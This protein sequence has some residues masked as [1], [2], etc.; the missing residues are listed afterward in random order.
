VLAISDDGPGFDKNELPN[1]FER[2][3]KGKKGNFGLGLSISKNVIERLNGKISAE[4]L[5][6]G[7]LFKIELPVIQVNH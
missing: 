5:Q 1:I 4:N 6:K 7:A 3:Y 2:F